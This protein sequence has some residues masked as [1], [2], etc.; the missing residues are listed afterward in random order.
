MEVFFNPEK[1]FAATDAKQRRKDIDAIMCF[2]YA[3]GM[4]AALD[5]RSR[6]Y[7]DTFIRDNFKSAQVPNGFTCYD[8]YY[9]LRKSKSWMPWDNMV[10]KFEFNKE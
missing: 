5:E 3:W 6:D 2:S 1:G 7:F 10:Q 8:Y 9:D 4:G